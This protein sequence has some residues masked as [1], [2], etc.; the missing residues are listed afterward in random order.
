LAWKTA[1]AN[2]TRKVERGIFFRKENGKEIWGSALVS[3]SSSSCS[4]Q[5]RRLERDASPESLSLRSSKLTTILHTQYLDR[6]LSPLPSPTFLVPDHPNE[7]VR[8]F[9]VDSRLRTKRVEVRKRNEMRGDSYATI[10]SGGTERGEILEMGWGL[11]WS[12]E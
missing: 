1:T 3:S 11:C 6:P 5:A 8:S 4:R 2:R 9:D 7:I 10:G 12:S